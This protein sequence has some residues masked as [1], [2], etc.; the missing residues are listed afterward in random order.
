MKKRIFYIFTIIF[1]L[2]FV[3]IYLY[4]D[5]KE[6]LAE[7]KL[8]EGF[9]PSYGDILSASDGYFIIL[10][11]VNSKIQDKDKDFLFYIFKIDF[12]GNVLWRKTLNE[13]VLKLYEVPFVYKDN[14]YFLAL[15]TKH[16]STEDTLF[17]EDNTLFM[18]K[19]S[20]EIEKILKIDDAI[21][22]VEGIKQVEDSKFILLISDEVNVGTDKETLFRSFLKIDLYKKNYEYLWSIP[23][24]KIG[25]N[26]IFLTD[27][28]NK[29]FYKFYLETE[30][31][32]EITVDI[33]EYFDV[34]NRK[35]II[36]LENFSIYDFFKRND[37]FYIFADDYSEDSPLRINMFIY[38]LNGKKILEK[39]YK[40]FDDNNLLNSKKYLSI[41]RIVKIFD[42]KFLIFAKPYKRIEEEYDDKYSIL[43]IDTNGKKIYEKESDGYIL[44]DA[45]LKDNKII[46]LASR[47]NNPDNKILILQQTYTKEKD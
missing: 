18:I 19:K 30:G 8:D 42:N 2:F 46:T 44:H 25:G 38:S 20:G 35:K 13:N 9:I 21:E 6:I 39:S 4:K 41:D 40:L 11:A 7:I 45:I 33:N 47:G 3:G 14:L 12:N 16:K 28:L 23:M 26:L 1:V 5:N 17:F 31:L 34:I 27:D 36:S 10:K 43:V 29:N 24:Y 22:S 37:K 32:T 15:N